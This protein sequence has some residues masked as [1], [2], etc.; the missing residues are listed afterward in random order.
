[1]ALALEEELVRED[2]TGR[3]LDALIEN[4]GDKQISFSG[5]ALLGLYRLSQKAEPLVEAKEVL[6]LA[7]H[8]LEESGYAN[9]NKVVALQVAGLSGSDH[10]LDLARSYVADQSAT[11]Q[12]RVSAIALLGSRGDKDD[13]A[14]IKPLT[15][16]L[17]FRLR[18]AAQAALLK[19]TS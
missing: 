3:S 12:L 9:T 11:I 2:L 15:Q 4:A 18:K 7:E 6:S 19:L 14:A 5:T 16:N 1:L 10:A 13:I 17:D 8:V